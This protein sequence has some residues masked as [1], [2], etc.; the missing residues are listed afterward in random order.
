MM[1]AAMNAA[2][3]EAATTASNGLSMDDFPECEQYRGIPNRYGNCRGER[4]TIEKCNKWRVAFSLPPLPGT[5]P[6]PRT[7]RN[8][9]S[10]N[11][12]TGI[13]GKDAAKLERKP[14]ATGSPKPEMPS[15]L[16]RAGTF[17]KAAAR[18]IVK[19]SPQCTEEQIAAR[20]AICEAC[21][22]FDNNH[23]TACG[24]ACNSKK[25]FLNK[26]AWADQSCPHPDGARWTAIT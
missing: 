17:L 13:G 10:T 23:C 11:G 5:V 19:G 1:E 20:L 3:N 15:L 12:G 24:C 9:A 8:R 7:T 4:L 22:L 2:A 18:H 25:K 14:K 26:L 21:P 6:P 16:A